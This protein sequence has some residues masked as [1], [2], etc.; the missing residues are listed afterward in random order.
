VPDVERG[1]HHQPLPA[2]LGIGGGGHAGAHGPADPVVDRSGAVERAQVGD[3]IVGERRIADH[4]EPQRPGRDPHELPVA[5]QRVH[6]AQR[7]AAQ[8]EVVAQ[9]RPRAGRGRWRRGRLYGL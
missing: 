1:L 9:Q 4:E 5:A 7:I 3:H 6:E 8:H 2:V